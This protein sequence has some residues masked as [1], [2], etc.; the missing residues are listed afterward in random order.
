MGALAM[1]SDFA[2]VADGLRSAGISDR[3]ISG[4]VVAMFLDRSSVARYGTVGPRVAGCDP[5]GFSSPIL[6][7]VFQRFRFRST[8]QRSHLPD[9]FSR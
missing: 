4:L 1:F 8:R 5:L 7:R 6:E 3:E 2:M 9:Q